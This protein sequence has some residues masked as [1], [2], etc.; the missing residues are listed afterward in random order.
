MGP[1]RYISFVGLLSLAIDVTPLVMAIAYMVRPNETRLALM[2]PL[3]LAGIFAALSGGVVGLINALR[4]IWIRQEPSP[5]AYRIALIGVSESL[6]PV[7][8]GFACLSV[9]WLLVAAGMGRRE[10]LET[11]GPSLSR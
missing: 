9:A 6:V 3:S 10:R 7:F 4:A 1:L 11:L 5:E 8:V 2:R